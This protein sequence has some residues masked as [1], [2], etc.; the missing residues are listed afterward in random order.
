[1]SRSSGN[2]YNAWERITRQKHQQ[3]GTT[4][5]INTRSS[6]CS[7]P[8]NSRTM[9]STRNI[10]VTVN[11]SSSLGQHGS[12]AI[13]TNTNT[14]RQQRTII[15]WVT[16]SMVRTTNKCNEWSIMGRHTTA[17][18]NNNVQQYRHQCRWGRNSHLNGQITVSSATEWV[19]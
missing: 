10:N 9:G 13:I 18:V 17:C 11:G 15:K 4:V 2:V 8:T 19:S 1:M 5:I 3:H 14:T 12:M 7:S 6:Q 16:G